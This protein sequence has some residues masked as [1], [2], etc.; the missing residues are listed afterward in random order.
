M[1]SDER[2]AICDRVGEDVSHFLEACGEFERYWLV[3]LDEVCR[4]VGAREWLDELWRVDMESKVALLLGKGVD[5]I[6]NRV[7]ED[8]GEC[9]LY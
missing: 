6:Y 7:V 3:L 2:C 5:C 8:V 4:I 9:I 1:I